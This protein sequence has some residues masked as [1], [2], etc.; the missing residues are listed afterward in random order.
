MLIATHWCFSKFTKPHLSRKIKIYSYSRANFSFCVVWPFL[1]END[2]K[3]FAKV[4]VHWIIFTLWIYL[5]MYSILICQYEWEYC[6][7]DSFTL[8]KTNI[9]SVWNLFLDFACV[10]PLKVKQCSCVHTH[11]QRWIKTKLSQ[12]QSNESYR[13]RATVT[14]PDHWFVHRTQKK[15]NKKNVCVIHLFFARLFASNQTKK[16]FISQRHNFF[17]LSPFLS[18]KKRT[19]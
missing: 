19:T 14:S 15:Q 2:F 7:I 18:W 16:H 11:R 10:V 12:N 5:F 3:M 8:W 13:V 6:Q 1:I 17:S 4:D 9:F